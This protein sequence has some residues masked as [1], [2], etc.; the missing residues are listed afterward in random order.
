LQL[1]RFFEQNPR[2]AVAFSGGVD[3]SYLLNAA[4]SAGCDIRAYFVKSEFQPEF[5][6]NDAI[7]VAKSLGVALMVDN[8]CILNEPGIASNPVDRCY[9]CKT[10]IFTR[11]RELANK[12][13]FSV[14][15][16]GSNADDLEADRPGMRAL[17]ELGV[18][19]PLRDSGL[20]KSEIR[21]LSARAGLRTHDKPPYA[22]L[23][24]RIPT[25]TAITQDFLAMIDCAETTLLKMGFSNFR[26]RLIPPDTAKIQVPDKQWDE[27]AARRLEILEALKPDFNSI[28]LDMAGR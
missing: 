3:S 9:H 19:S 17:R 20:R 6:L 8:F 24:T 27:V 28:V 11:L 10:K 2:F 18:I 13:G 21:R 15:C 7:R 16:D 25:G 5:E 12:D 22:C 1:Q 14:L 26:V 4:V 23:A